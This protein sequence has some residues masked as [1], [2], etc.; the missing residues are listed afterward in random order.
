[1]I[2]LI[3]TAFWVLAGGLACAHLLRLRQM[4]LS[5]M[6]ALGAGLG[7]AVLSLAMAASLLPKP[8][9][10]GLLLGGLAVLPVYLYRFY[11]QTFE[12]SRLRS[13]P[14]P[15]GSPS[16]PDRPDA[17]DDWPLGLTP[18]GLR[19]AA[20]A[21][22]LLAAGRLR[23]ANLGY[24]EFQ[25]DEARAMLLAQELGRSGSPEAIL[26]HK[27]G[28]IELLLP[29]PGPRLNDLSERTARLP[30]ALAGLAALLGAW[31]L[32]ARLF[33]S[34]AG[35]LAAMLMAL[36]G[37]LIA[38]SRIV[39]YQSIVLLFS[40]LA[41]WCAWRFHRRAA[42]AGRCLLLAG[43]FLGL[44]SWA[45]YEMI[46]AVP[47]VAWL[48]LSRGVSERWS[49]RVWLRRLAPPVTLAAALCLAFYLPFV[50]HPQFARTWDYISQRRVGGGMPYNMLG[51]WFT[52]ASFYNAS[53]FVIAVALILI[54]VVLRLLVLAWGGT[55]RILGGLWLLGLALLIARPAWLQIGP[56]EADPPRSLALL[57][58]LPVL[59]A[60]LAAPRLDA[61]WRMLLLWLAGPFFAAAFLVKKPHTHFYTMLPAW[62]L[63]AGWGLDQAV[64]WLETRLGRLRGRQLAAGL[65]ALLLLVFFLHQQV[66]FVRH[67][68]EYKR[69]WPEA[70]LAGYWQ[71]FEALPRGG[72]FGFPYRAGWSTVR[73]MFRAGLLSGSYDSNEEAL[74]T[75]WYT[76][77]APRCPEAP[78]YYLV[79]W[80]PQ[81][82]EPIP[83]DLAG[84]GYHLH[85]QIL[86]GGQTKLEVYQRAPLL[87]DAPLTVEDD[88]SIRRLLRDL[89]AAAAAEPGGPPAPRALRDADRSIAAAAA[90]GLPLVE[91]RRDWRFGEA[92][93][94]LGADYPLLSEA[95][96]A[97]IASRRAKAGTAPAERHSSQGEAALG[98][99]LVWQALAPIETNLSVFVHLV[100]A[101]GNTVAQSDGWPDCG[102]APSS[103]WGRDEAGAYMADS[104]AF[105]YD[106]HRLLLPAEGLPPGEYRVRAGLYQAETGQRLPA[107]P[108]ADP[109]AEPFDAIELWS[110]RIT[111]AAD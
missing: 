76:M 4:D 48:I 105:V 62:L 69:V 13:E 38:F 74:I 104:T 3:I 65:G 111:D 89:D 80:R 54:A 12:A 84:R 70:R 19:V 90:L 110:F 14:D 97:P 98:V 49:P 29:A 53:Y 39:Q 55:G 59:A 63:M 82:A 47:P 5:E 87:T 20:L 88:G 60:L 10:A 31:A 37:Y 66:V 108:M 72:Y 34:R 109:M 71:P 27:K 85:A 99:S 26:Q 32:G 22:L 78:D 96:G 36:D 18:A 6:L 35:W 103:G 68:P 9:A 30:F 81:D 28:P 25:G 50:R 33:G 79:A 15:D 73:E 2:A 95:Y 56:T 93:R 23:L 1:M 75:G 92:I 77:G 44:G 11:R 94:L 21:L 16:E 101:A 46:F 100:D 86:V 58:F 91:D 102:R 61:R 64:G 7:L 41:V 51:D 106:Q 83:D 43:F 45:H 8:W 67:D 40:V 57:V 107:R 52:R 24:A 17:G 42:D